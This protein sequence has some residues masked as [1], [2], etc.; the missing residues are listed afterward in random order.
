MRPGNPIAI[1]EWLARS[2]NVPLT[3]VAEFTDTYEHAPCRYQDLASAT[4]A[5]TNELNVCPRHKAALSLDELLPHRSRI[6]DLS[7]LLHSSDPDWDAPED[8]P[9]LLQHQFFVKTLPNLQHLDFRAFHV[10]QEERYMIN[11]PSSLFARELP[12]LT[13]LKYLGVTGGL[14][15]TAKNLTSCEIGYWSRAAGPIILEINDLQT[16]FNNNRT[17]ESLTINKCFFGFDTEAPTIIP[18]PDLKFLTID[19]S[20]RHD[21]RTILS[22]IHA[23]RLSDLDTVQLSLTRS[24]IRTIATGG[25]GCT[26]R[27]SWLCYEELK[28]DPMR[29]LGADIT[30]LRLGEGLPTGPLVRPPSLG[31]F[32]RSLD[33]VRVL[34]FDGMISDRVQ[35][36]LS[37]PRLLQGLEVIQVGIDKANYQNTLQCLT[38]SARSRMEKGKR[39][40]AIRPFAA[41]GC[42]SELNHGLR[43]EW[44]KCF[45]ENGVAGFLVE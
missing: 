28:F 41:E 3:V 20:S 45:E 27:F 22:S 24:H 15:E 13:E 19:C 11:T 18:M 33:S 5:A 8:G 21:L 35:N 30:T 38:F 16:L 25:S 1:S 40:T 32:L 6:H 31:E 29:H 44:E 2:Q 9:I 34:E 42:E 14:I 23:P 12:R 17:L 26:V 4:L 7:I 10:E 37:V 36:I 39:L 43:E